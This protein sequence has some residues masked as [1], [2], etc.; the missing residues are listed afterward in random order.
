MRRVSIAVPAARVFGDMPTY[1]YQCDACGDL[2]EVQQS[3]TDDSIPKCP[4]RPKVCTSRRKADVRKV[5]SAPGIAF[6]GS[7]FYKND[8]RSGGSKSSSSSES[9]SSESTGESSSDTSSSSTSAKSD[10]KKSDTTSSDSKKS[11]T[12]KSDA[13]KAPKKASASKD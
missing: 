7:G 6:K 5:F 8:A 2:F 4:N 10:G 3:F 1:E 12:K 13:K 9:S 11:E